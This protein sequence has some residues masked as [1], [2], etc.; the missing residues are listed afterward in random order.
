MISVHS[1]VWPYADACIDHIAG[2]LRADAPPTRPTPGGWQSPMGLAR[3]R[4]FSGAIPRA[5]DA[6]RECMEMT[7]MPITTA[8]LPMIFPSH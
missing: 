2:I 5:S 1:G 4:S 7:R 3:P 8:A 6:Q